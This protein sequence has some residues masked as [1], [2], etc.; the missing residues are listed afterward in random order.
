M[1]RVFRRLRGFPQNALRPA[2]ILAALSG[3]FSG[4]AAVGFAAQSRTAL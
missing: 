1:V 2:E 3:V 4:F